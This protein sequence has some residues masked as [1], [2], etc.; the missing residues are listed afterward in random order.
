MEESITFS[1][2][3]ILHQNSKWSNFHDFF[4]TVTRWLISS[5][6]VSWRTVPL[7]RTPSRWGSGTVAP[8]CTT[9]SGMSSLTCLLPAHTMSSVRLGLSS[10]AARFFRTYAGCRQQPISLKNLMYFKYLEKMC[11]SCNLKDKG[12]ISCGVNYNHRKCLI[13]LGALIFLHCLLLQKREITSL[14]LH[15][16]E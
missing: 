9:Q 10:S 15:S 2:R 7:R 16:K 6:L 1:T 14:Y 8:L 5:S 11:T 3:I 13:F 4:D 12:V